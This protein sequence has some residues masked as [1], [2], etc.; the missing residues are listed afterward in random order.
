MVYLKISD[1][2]ATSDKLVE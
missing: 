2:T 1:R